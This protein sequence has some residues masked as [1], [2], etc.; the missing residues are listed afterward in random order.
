VIV[1]LADAVLR[2]ARGELVAYPTETV[3][4]LGADAF[5]AEALAALVAL[6]G[7]DAERGMSVLVPDAAA[8]ALIA[9]PLPPVATQLAA[10]FWPG[11]LTL[12]VPVADSRF[13]GVCTPL[14]VGFRCSPQPTAAALARA[15]VQPIVSTSCNRSGAT[16]CSTAADVER[17]FGRELAI[18]GGEAAAGLAPS[19]VVAVSST[20]ALTLLR[21]GSIPWDEIRAISESD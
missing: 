11:P 16:P 4:G 18:L 15:S 8:L 5:S 12:V 6:K 7:R 9:A 14:G 13:A 2:L 17:E 21:P 1:S 10:R 3:Y 19:T 20:G